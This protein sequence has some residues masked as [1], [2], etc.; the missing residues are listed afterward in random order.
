[1]KKSSVQERKRYIPIFL[2]VL[3]VVGLLIWFFLNKDQLGTKSGIT[4]S[5]TPSQLIPSV[6]TAEAKTTICNLKKEGLFAEA[7]QNKFSVVG[8]EDGEKI[9]EL[10]TL[11]DKIQ[12][13]KSLSDYDRLLLGQ[14]V[15]ASLPTKDSPQAKLDYSLQAYL[16][17]FLESKNIAYAR[18]Q[19]MSGE[20]FKKIDDR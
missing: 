6:S 3:A 14:V 9:A 12:N 8:K 15:F 13:D 18:E 5:I 16:R 10:F 19:I 1:M 2:T 17:D 4:V 20:E 11:I 7:C